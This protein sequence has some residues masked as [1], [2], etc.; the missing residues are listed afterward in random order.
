MIVMQAKG[1]AMRDAFFCQNDRN[2]AGV[3]RCP[4]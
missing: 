4:P 1:S 2:S 3:A